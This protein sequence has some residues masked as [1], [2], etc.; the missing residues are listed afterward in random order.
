MV[1]RLDRLVVAGWWVL[2]ASLGPLD[3]VLAQRFEVTVS[4][5]AHPGPL[6]GRLMLAVSKREQPE[7]RL[8]IS[9]QGPAIFGVD[10]EQLQA[11]QSVVVDNRA[12]AYPMRLRDLPLGDYFVQALVIPYERIRRADGHTIWVR[13]NDGTVEAFN[14]AAGNLY[15][16]VR[17]VTV[18]RGDTT[19]VRL[20]VDNV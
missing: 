20:Q 4:Q 11:G 16:G 8:A 5:T 12:V 2:A 13:M 15:S 10:L 14:R 3:T 18:A 6:T 17:R 1:K 9:P 19:V 7:P